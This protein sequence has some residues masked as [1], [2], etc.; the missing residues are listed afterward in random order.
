MQFVVFGAIRFPASNES[1][2]DHTFEGQNCYFYLKA[3]EQ[4]C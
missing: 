3:K 4:I 1:C 2:H